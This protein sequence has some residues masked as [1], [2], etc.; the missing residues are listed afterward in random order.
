[1]SRT[2][3]LQLG[4]EMETVQI[5]SISSSTDNNT[6]VHRITFESIG[7][8]DDDS[9]ENGWKARKRKGGSS[10]KKKKERTK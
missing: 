6:A 5:P 8:S 10:P 4:K 1:M 9:Y 2:S 3:R 7:E